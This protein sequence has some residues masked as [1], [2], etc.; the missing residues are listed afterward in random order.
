[1]LGSAVRPIAVFIPKDDMTLRGGR[2][3]EHEVIMLAE[4]R[5]LPAILNQAFFL[6]LWAAA[7][8]T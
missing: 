2:P 8:T 1:M 5:W 3:I 7:E 6:A 4:K